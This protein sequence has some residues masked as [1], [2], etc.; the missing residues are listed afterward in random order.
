MEYYQHKV[1]VLQRHCEDVGRDPGE[2]SHSLLLPLCLSENKETV[3]A[4]RK[5]NGK[6]ALAGSRNFVIDTLG[7]FADAGVSETY[8]SHLRAGD[9][10]QF[11]QVEEEIVAAFG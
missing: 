4:F 8:F 7:E 11:Q 10:E 6:D 9:V 3:Q 2:I 5:R 1:S